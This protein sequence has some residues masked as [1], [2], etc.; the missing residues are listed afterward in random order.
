M[1]TVDLGGLG[2][3]DLVE[4][5]PPLDLNA[6]TA[7]APAD[8]A[9]H[10]EPTQTVPTQAD[11]HSPAPKHTSNPSP[12]DADSVAADSTH[13][14]LVE[15]RA[16]IEGGSLGACAEACSEGH[17]EEEIKPT[18][19]QPRSSTPVASADAPQSLR[20]HAFPD[21]GWE[22]SSI[23]PAAGIPTAKGLSAGAAATSPAVWTGAAGTHTTHPWDLLSAGSEFPARR[24]R[25]ASSHAF[26]P[27]QS[28]SRPEERLK[29]LL[30]KAPCYAALLESYAVARSGKETYQNR[31]IQLYGLTAQ[32]LADRITVDKAVMTAMNL[33]TPRFTPAH[34]VDALLERALG[35]L[36]PQGTDLRALETDRDVVWELAQDGLAYRDYIST[37][38]AIAA[39]KK[40]RSQCPLRVRVNQRVS[41]MMDILKTMPDLKTQ[42]FEI[43]S[44]SMAKYLQA[45]Q[46][47]QPTFEEFWNRHLETGY[48]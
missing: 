25:R 47:E 28:R 10:P 13:G 15:A 2:S 23:P 3:D 20:V 31:N 18:S 44:A 11:S 4:E 27:S 45:L 1:P 48:E 17:A 33:P 22:S 6:F 41:R 24:P 9:P 26:A 8:S 37:D 35:A 34:Y 36:N 39:L 12:E 32:E 7:K 30:V 43:I 14:T 21:T 29:E 38:P 16:G 40:P 5:L 19:S 42:P 46:T